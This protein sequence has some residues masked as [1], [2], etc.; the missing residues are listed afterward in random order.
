MPSSGIIQTKIQSPAN[1]GQRTAFSWVTL[2]HRQDCTNTYK[3]IALYVYNRAL[4][5]EKAYY[6]H[7]QYIIQCTAMLNPLLPPTTKTAV[8]TSVDK[9]RR[10]ITYG[11]IRVYNA[12]QPHGYLWTKHN[13][14]IID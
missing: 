11:Q 5:G 10:C 12:R 6:I 8:A 2:V 3:D 7:A 13:N 14:C 9:D 4:C 1:K